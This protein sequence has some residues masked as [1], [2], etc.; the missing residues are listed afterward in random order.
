MTKHVEHK[1]IPEVGGS[2]STAQGRWPDKG[3]DK[4]GE[5]A[6]V[7]APDLVSLYA[8]VLVMATRMT[9]T[10]LD[11]HIVTEL[12]A[13]ACPSTLLQSQT[14]HSELGLVAVRYYEV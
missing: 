11:G 14:R 10:V 2:W 1:G 8:S 5:G 9:R 6:R 4:T 3:A 7:F 12:V 13:S